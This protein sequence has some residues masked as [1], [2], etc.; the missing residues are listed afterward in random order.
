MNVIK[1]DP[2]DAYRVNV[3][4]Q[5]WYADPLASCVVAPASDT[6]HPSVSAVKKA[7]ASDWTGVTLHRLATALDAN[8]A[9]YKGMDV[10]DIKALMTHTDKSGLNAAGQ[11]GTNVHTIIEDLMAGRPVSINEGMP[12]HNYL[13]AATAM[14]AALDA[15]LLYAECVLFNRTLHGKGFGGTADAIVRLPDGRT[16]IVDWKSRGESNTVYAS[17][18]S[19]LGL[20]SLAGYLI[21]DGKRHPMP[22]IDGLLIASVTP[23]GHA[24][25]DINLG[26]A[27]ASGVALHAWWTATQHDRDGIAK[28]VKSLPKAVTAAVETPPTAAV[29]LTPQE[30]HAAVSSRFIDGDEDE[31]GPAD[32]AAYILL[33]QRYK[34]L[35]KDGRDWISDIARQATQH[36]VGFHSSFD[37]TVRRFEILRGLVMLAAVEPGTCTANEAKAFALDCHMYVDGYFTARCDTNGRVRLLAA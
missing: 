12:G 14:L 28:G 17:E 23:T 2:A 1:V 3:D 18:K 34:E 27:Q 10:V 22:V 7:A 35:D 24:F 5:R 36:G 33:E 30:Q 37:K 15:E 26:A 32:V 9:M 11:R 8:P 6:V 20:Y 13:A 4:G 19:Q 29:V 16:V 21:V 31:G 25:Y